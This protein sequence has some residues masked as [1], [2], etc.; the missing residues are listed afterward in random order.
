[1]NRPPVNSFDAFEY[2]HSISIVRNIHGYSET[3]TIDIHRVLSQGIPFYSLTPRQGT[4]L[5]TFDIRT[6]S[7]LYISTVSLEKAVAVW[8]ESWLTG[9]ELP[10]EEYLTHLD[11]ATALNTVEEDGNYRILVVGAKTEK[12][13]GYIHWHRTSER[14]VIVY[15]DQEACIFRSAAHAGNV[16]TS[17]LLRD[18]NK[19]LRD[20][21]A[22]ILELYGED[23]AVVIQKAVG[24]NGNHWVTQGEPEITPVYTHQNSY[25]E[26]IKNF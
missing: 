24:E 19:Q 26:R 21:T 15:D 11:Y 25:I 4:E 18:Q 1:M 7:A 2:L 12:V 22:T 14:F 3:S 6:R 16:L 20:C 17:M 13:L 8:R 23:A 10:C 9:I 5:S